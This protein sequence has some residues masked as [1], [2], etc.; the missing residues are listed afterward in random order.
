MIA[1]VVSRSP[2]HTLLGALCAGIAVANVARVPAGAAAPA[3][4]IVLL[5]A[6]VSEQSLRRLI[7][8]AAALAL[9]GWAWGSARLDAL[10]RSPLLA[11]LGRVQPAQLVVTAPARTG[12]FDLRLP[13]TVTAFGDLRLREPVLLRL[14]LGRAPPQGA[15]IEATAQIE[16]PRGPEDDFDESTY[17]RRHGVHVVL[18]ARRWRLLGRR[19]GLGG[20]ADRLRRGLEGVLRSGTSGE[21]EELLVGVVLGDDT[22]LS[23]GLRE[24]F[25]AS[26]LYHLLTLDTKDR[27]VYPEFMRLVGYTRVSRVGGREGERFISP[28][29]QR[30][31]IRAYAKAHGHKIAAWEED[32]DEPGSRLDRPGFERALARV[33]GGRAEGIIAARLD[34]LTRSV[35]GLGTLLEDARE[36]GWN[37]IAVDLGLD[38]LTSNGK[39]VANVLGSIAE[40][41]LDRRRE[42]WATAQEYAVRRG[43]HVA[44]KV[45]TGYRRGEEGRLEPDPESAPVIADVFRRRA[46]GASWRELAA[47]LMGAGVATPY[48]ASTWA[49]GSVAKLVRNR[50]YLGEARSGEHRNPGAHPP[51]VTLAEWTAAQAARAPATTQASGDG[52]LLAGLLRCAGCRFVMKADRMTLRDGSR[53][54]IYRC[55]GEHAA[56]L[57]TARASVMG[58]VI[59]PFVVERFFAA[60][61]PGGLLARASRPTAGVENLQR[62]LAARQAELAAWRDDT[63]ILEVGRDVYV[64]GLAARQKRVLEAEEALG[65]AFADQGGVDLPPDVELTELWPELTLDEQRRLLAAGIDCVM[66]RQGRT[67]PIEERALI[68]FRGQAPKDLPGRGRRVPLEP[69]RWPNEPPL[70]AA[71]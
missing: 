47:V 68:L 46:E 13:A 51:I 29:V 40:W 10:D 14:P 25:R 5:T 15:V 70:A 53:A 65:A 58:R 1:A 44:S 12:R 34:R 37:L 52:S 60:L 22:R 17:L 42:T 69:F 49:T 23:D 19:G 71:A 41:E 8:V 64:Q 7:L 16:L 61:G 2:L 59:E 3:A 50:V 55:R 67:L 56:G 48:G 45:P 33:R 27:T 4:A 11:E 20:V 36:N 21:R 54:R 38:L 43:V 28:E 66:L 24:R 9:T 39:L 57:C 32:L 26:G 6:A 35:A 62:D 18:V 30:D 63:G 31:A